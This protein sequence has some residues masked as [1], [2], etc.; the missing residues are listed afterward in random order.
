MTDSTKGLKPLQ[1]LIGNV[2]HV[3][4]DVAIAPTFRSGIPNIRQ[5]LARASALSNEAVTLSKEV[6]T[7]KSFN[8]LLRS[9]CA[10]VFIAATAFAQQWQ[11]VGS[12][13]GGGVTDLAWRQTGNQLW[14]TTGSFNWPQVPGG[15]HRST[16]GGLAWERRYN[17]AFT[18]RTIEIAPDGRIYA[19]IWF[20]PLNEGIFVS[21]NGDLWTGP[22]YQ[23]GA[24]DNVFCIGP[25]PT[26]I[27]IIFAGT[28]NAVVRTTN[29]G[30]NWAVVN[31]G[32]P[33]NTWVRSLAIDSS[34]IVA[35][36]TTN[37]LFISTDNGGAW[38]RATGINDTVTALLFDDTSA[39]ATFSG[40]GRRLIAGTDEPAALYQSFANSGYLTFT[41]VALFGDGHVAGIA[42]AAL[43][44]GNTKMHG[45]A[46]FKQ[47]GSG[48]GIHFSTDGARTFTADN[49][50]LPTPG[51][52]SALTGY[53]VGNTFNWFVGVLGNSATGANVYRKSIVT[54][55]DNKNV[56]V[57]SAFELFQNYP[58]PFNPSTTIRYTLS[59][60]ERAGVRSNHVILKVFDLLGQEVATLV[61]EVK[62]PGEHSVTLD[63]TQ[64]SSG[65]YFYRLRAGEFQATKKLL[66]LK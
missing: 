62:E 38:T 64:M 40:S 1:L 47:T 59:S 13:I 6:N 4:K 25:H 22:I 43:Q 33:T 44:T 30:T 28:R 21:P 29:Q 32:I 7:M 17:T 24:S 34:G 50:G 57:P 39:T 46:I 53:T 36:G 63:A 9:L 20:F 8:V 66:L 35:A 18:A 42:Q 19:S 55:V 51:L 3:L 2:I 15:V 41:L 49:Q 10:I 54:A 61:D 11:Q 27:Q 65:V 45:V 14:A 52:T 31:N 58:N 48:G 16:N 5:N 37:G 12:P 23:V 60:Q 56:L 26:N